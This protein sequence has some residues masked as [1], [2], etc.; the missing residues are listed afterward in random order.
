MRLQRERLQRVCLQES[1]RY[2]L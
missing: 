2:T 1:L